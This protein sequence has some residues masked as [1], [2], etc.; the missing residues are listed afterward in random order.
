MTNCKSVILLGLTCCLFPGCTFP[1]QRLLYIEIAVDGET[2]LEARRG[3]PDSTPIE[4]MWDVL[5]D[6][7]FAAPEIASEAS[8]SR[9]K[10]GVEWNPEE[11]VTVTI[12][13]G[14][15]E[16][17]SS[18]VESLAWIPT[19]DGWVLQVGELERLKRAAR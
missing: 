8:K 11:E 7:Q 19:E 17:A 10:P 3:V 14:E 4:E 9:S 13:H 1:G 18:T 16:L 5:V 6:L 15:S 12:F 2:R